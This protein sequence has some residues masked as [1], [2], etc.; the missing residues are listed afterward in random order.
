MP[1]PTRAYSIVNRDDPARSSATGTLSS[2]RTSSSS[3]AATCAMG[4]AASQPLGQ[5]PNRVGKTMR[6][7]FDR[8]VRQVAGH[9]AQGEPLGRKTRTVA[10]V[11]AL[12]LAGDAEPSSYRVHGHPAAGTRRRAIY[13]GVLAGASLRCASAR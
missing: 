4:G 7:D 6:D 5:L 3:I 12:N 1:G 9:A 13:C 8:P 10:K 11:H 2:S